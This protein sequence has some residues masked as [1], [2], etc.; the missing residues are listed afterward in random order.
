MRRTSFAHR[1]AISSRC[2]DLIQMPM[3][4]LRAFAGRIIRTTRS[5]S[6]WVTRA[7]PL[8]RCLHKLIEDFP[9]TQI[10]IV[11][12]SGREGY[13]RQSCQTGAAG[14]GSCSRA[15]GDQRQRCA[16][17]ADL[18]A[19]ARWTFGGRKKQARSL[20]FMCLPKKKRGCSG[21]KMLECSPIFTRAS[22]LRNSSMV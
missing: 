2:E 18:P 14:R 15:P 9:Q 10:R 22:L 19:A 11:I 17:R 16:C 12:G 13:Q 4:T 7:T 6:V 8:C 21:C 5:C 20:A 3:R 1:L